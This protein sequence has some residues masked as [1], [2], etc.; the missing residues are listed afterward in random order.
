M[1][2]K[3]LYVIA[4]SQGYENLCYLPN[5]VIREDFSIAHIK[6]VNKCTDK[7]MN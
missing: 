3:D 4:A 1:K 5:L 2:V 7:G 6:R